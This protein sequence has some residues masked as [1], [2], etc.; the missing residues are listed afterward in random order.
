MPWPKNERIAADFGQKSERLVKQSQDKQT[1]MHVSLTNSCRWHKGVR[2]AG[3]LK[4]F[5]V[6]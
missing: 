5:Q 2:Q 4:D 3:P 6:A 1:K